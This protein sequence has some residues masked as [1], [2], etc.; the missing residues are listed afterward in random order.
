M[1]QFKQNFINVNFSKLKKKLPR[2]SGLSKEMI[3]FY[4]SKLQVTLDAQ[5][6][7]T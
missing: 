2:R 7:L 6:I 4:R 5:K 1:Y 3:N